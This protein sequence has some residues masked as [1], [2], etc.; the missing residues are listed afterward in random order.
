MER[1]C[2]S[3]KEVKELTSEHFHARRSDRLGFDTICKACKKLKDEE[4]YKKKRLKILEQKKRY[5]QRKKKR[6]CISDGD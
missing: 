6:A 3:C 4:R 1:C 2:S 5:Y